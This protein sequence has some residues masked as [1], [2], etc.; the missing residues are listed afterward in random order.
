MPLLAA[1]RALAG[2][3]PLPRP[4]VRLR[5]TLLYGALFV[6]SGAALIGITYA[7]A[8]NRLD[9]VAVH[10]AG[11]SMSAATAPLVARVAPGAGRW[12]A[13]PGPGGGFVFVQQRADLHQFVVEAGIALA[14]MVGV[15]LALGW[16][17]AGRVLRPLRTV[18]AATRRISEHNLGARLALEGPRD[19][20][21]DLADTIDALLGRLEGAFEAQRRFVANASHELRTPLTLSRALLEVALAD[22][23]ARGATLRGTCERVLAAQ[24]DQERLIEALL[25]LARSQRGLERRDPLDLAAVAREVIETHDAQA[26]ARGV[27]VDA[28][29]TTAQTLGERRLVGRLVSNLVDNAIRY[30]VAGGRLQVAVHAR[31]DRVVLRVAN[32]GPRVPPDQVP[33]LLQ[34]FQ[35]L[36]AGRGTRHDGL[37]LGLSIVAAIAQAHGAT[38]EVLPGD[39]G[40]L[41]VEVAFLVVEDAVQAAAGAR[42]GYAPGC[43]AEA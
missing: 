27:L 29:L 15:A 33:R 34:P 25:M 35:R 19:E 26:G 13:V 20:I 4:T 1:W 42:G 14:M 32:T 41:E 10:A 43:A 23:D 31:G 30:N 37:G 9:S 3:L 22:P 24:A 5:L 11:G 36:N 12:T 2:R 39:E 16:L 17:M 21:R 7:L 18:T 40:G 38:L 8:A 6:V 28:A